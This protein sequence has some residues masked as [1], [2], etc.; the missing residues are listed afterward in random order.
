MNVIPARYLDIMLDCFEYMKT[1]GS[2]ANY[3]SWIQRNSL[4]VIYGGT[5]PTASAFDSGWASL[6]EP[7]AGSE[8]LVKYEAQYARNGVTS[9]VDIDIIPSSGRYCVMSL[10][11]RVLE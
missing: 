7:V 2:T 4:I 1:D 3:N 11:H 5:M 6:Y 8:I 9:T 10:N